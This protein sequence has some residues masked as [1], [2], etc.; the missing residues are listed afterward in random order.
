MESLKFKKGLEE[1]LPKDLEKDTIYITTDTKK[2]L[3]NDAVWEDT[4]NIK[5]IINEN[6]KVTASALNDLSNKIFIGTQEEYDIAYAKGKIN[7]GSLVIILDE[8][9]V[10]GETTT[11][12]LG[13]AIIGALLLGKA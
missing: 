10:N 3:L 7:V 5:K 6:E 9:E 13:K 4:E 2:I 1:N 8:N 11:A 12:I